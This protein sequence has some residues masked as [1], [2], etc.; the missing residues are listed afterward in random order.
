MDS[1]GNRGDTQGK[2]YGVARETLM[3]DPKVSGQLVDIR[4]TEVSPGS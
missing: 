3:N 2:P 4:D 1:R